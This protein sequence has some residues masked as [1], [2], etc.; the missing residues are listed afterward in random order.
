MKHVLGQGKVCPSCH[1]KLATHE[2]A[3]EVDGKVYHFRC[4]PTKPAKLNC[5]VGKKW[6]AGRLWTV[7]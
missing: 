2:D 1:I 3:V 5:H 6:D 4:N 7:Q